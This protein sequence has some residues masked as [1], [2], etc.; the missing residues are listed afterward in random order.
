MSKVY[1]YFENGVLIEANAFGANGTSIGEIVFNTSM[2]GYEEIITDPSYAGQFITFTTPE[3]G[4]VGINNADKE[5][6]GVYCKGVIVKNHQDVPSNFRCEESLNTFMTSNNILGICNI[7]TRHLTQMIRDEG[8]MMMIASTEISDQNELKMMLE[9]APRIEEINYIKEVSTTERYTHTQSSWNE[10]TLTFNE[11]EKS[12]KSIYALDFGAKLNILNELVSCGLNVEVVPH[13][14]SSES[15]IADFKADKIGGVFLSNGPGDPLVLKDEV[16]TVKA[17]LEAKIPMF[18]ICLGHQL[19]SVAHGY[20]TYKMKFGHHGANH[21]VID[22]AT[23]KVMI[24]SQNHGFAVSETDLPDN[25]EVT[26]RSLFDDSI[27]GIRRT[28]KKAF[29]FQGHPEASPGPHDVVDLFDQFIS[30]MEK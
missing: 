28:D 23:K 18:G 4:N 30:S 20:N 2:T 1:C 29:G 7:D 5:S 6:R 22:L 11:G 13:H 10:D 9:K 27:Q 8:A 19:L 17:L 12:N 24:S 16:E 14:T 25:I 3:I 15:I 21:P 26:H